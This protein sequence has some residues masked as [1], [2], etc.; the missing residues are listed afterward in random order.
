MEVKATP[1]LGYAEFVDDIE[2]LSEL[3]IS[4]RYG[5]AIFHCINSGLDRIQQHVTRAQQE[6]RLLDPE[7]LIITKPESYSDIQE[8]YLGE[9]L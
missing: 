9:L 2:K 6:G 3:R 7:V 8:V 5:L 4:Y 1:D